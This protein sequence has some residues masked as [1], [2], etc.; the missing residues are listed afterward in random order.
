MSIWKDI[1]EVEVR[2]RRLH[3]IIS[4][5][6]TGKD[7]HEKAKAGYSGGLDRSFSQCASCAEGCAATITSRTKDSAVVFHSPVG[8]NATVINYTIGIRS[9]SL[10]RNKQPYDVQSLCTN[11]REK[12]TIFGAEEKLR[13]TIR[14][15]EK[16][17]HPKFI[18]ISTS[19][20]SGI[21]GED[22]EAIADDMEEE[23]GYPIVPVYCEGFK[24]KIWSSGFDAG[25]HGLLRK[26]VKPPR[27]QQ[28]DLVNIFAFEG[29]DTFT[30]LLDR[31][32]LRTNYFVALASPEQLETM[33]EA[34]C[35]TS[36]CETLSLYVASALEERFGVPEVK[37]PPP[38]GADWTDIW[39]REIGRLTGREGEAERLI[40][41]DR[42]RYRAEI[43]DL[44][45]KLGGKKLYI[46]AGDSFGH[47]LGNVARSLG[48][49]L[50][51]ITTL[52][53][54]LLTDNPAS[55]NSME[56]LVETA[57]D[58]RNFTICNL[59]PYQ[60]IKI[61]QKLKP[62]FLLCRHNGMN[63]MGAK[64]GI[65]T[66]FEGDAN[67]S[68]GYQGIVRLGRRLYE[69][70]QTRK[71]VENI[72]GHAELPYSDWWMNESDPFYFSKGAANERVN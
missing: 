56:A 59:Q 37:S 47:N 32:G 69:A 2:E 16:R 18:Y 21:I 11:I 12:D 35:S 28:E 53:H 50:A 71:L 20:A 26:I 60:I 25:Y 40:A 17:F 22:I 63:A 66:L 48:V 27:K 1:P 52:H 3:S 29:T 30:P 49:E 33:S 39:L 41:E 44:R 36:I 55:V 72:A 15:A 70:L 46:T 51:G 4:Y 67:F 61:L 58:I 8:C 31:M 19:C 54:D 6:G 62:D 43:E 24:S 65:P 13:Q 10:S 68:C 45:E 9:V 38:Y 5:N 57:G 14:E 23:L 42:E 64:I 7:L 34:A